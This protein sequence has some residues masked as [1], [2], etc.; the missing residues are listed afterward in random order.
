[1]LTDARPALPCT[2]HRY[3][4]DGL[5]AVAVLAILAFHLGLAGFPAGFIGVDIFFVISGFVITRGLL[6]E[7]ERGKFSV[8]QFYVRRAGG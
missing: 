4:V 2:A 3:D 5:R 1:M 6:V 8:K 7:I